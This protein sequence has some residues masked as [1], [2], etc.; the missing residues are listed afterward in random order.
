V[1]PSSLAPDNREAHGSFHTRITITQLQA[2]TPGEQD[3]QTLAQILQAN[4]GPPA[5]AGLRER[6]PV[7]VD[8]PRTVRLAS[9]IAN[10]SQP[11]A[12]QL[13]LSIPL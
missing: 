8:M 6:G 10:P 9:K 1:A 3:V 11:A 13:A 2:E 4:A 5:A 12:S 7:V